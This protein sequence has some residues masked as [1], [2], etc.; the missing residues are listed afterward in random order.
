MV[1]RT[2]QTYRNSDKSLSPLISSPPFGKRKKTKQTEIKTYFS[3]IVKIQELEQEQNTPSASPLDWTL[4]HCRVIFNP[5]ENSGISIAEEFAF[6]TDNLDNLDSRRGH[7]RHVLTSP[8]EDV[9]EVPM[10]ITEG[11]LETNLTS[12]AFKK[13]LIAEDLVNQLTSLNADIQAIKIYLAETNALLIT[14]TQFMVKQEASKEK[15]FPTLNQDTEVNDP[16]IKG[17]LGKKARNKNNNTISSPKHSKAH[18]RIKYKCRSLQKDQERKKVATSTVKQSNLN[19]QKILKYKHTDKKKDRGTTAKPPKDK[20]DKINCKPESKNETS[21]NQIKQRT[22]L[23]VLE[24][25]QATPLLCDPAILADPQVTQ[26]PWETVFAKGKENKDN[27]EKKWVKNFDVPDVG[28]WEMI[29]VPNKLVISNYPKPLGLLSPA[30][31]KGHLLRVLEV[32]GCNVISLAEITQIEY[33]FYNYSHARAVITCT[34]KQ[35]TNKLYCLKEKLMELGMS[36]S[37]YF[38]NSSPPFPL[39]KQEPKQLSRSNQIHC[40][41]AGISAQLAH[42]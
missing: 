20:I 28:D 34:N 41:E 30:E 35:V 25:N 39:F 13:P 6:A 19:S 33:L 40:N 9:V 14:I 32:V 29:L 26:D 27:N 11:D 1:I 24:V 12:E 36:I 22:V 42:N 21:I 38:I 5:Y 7:R 16:S 37:R 8:N 31:R 15:T 2:R 18:K 4:D 3:P 17:H 23:D 10:N